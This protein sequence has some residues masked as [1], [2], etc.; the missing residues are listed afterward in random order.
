MGRCGGTASEDPHQ[1]GTSGIRHAEP[2]QSLVPIASPFRSRK[3][4]SNEKQKRPPPGLGRS[5]A[6]GYAPG[7][8]RAAAGGGIRP[9]V[10][11]LRTAE[12][13]E[14]QFDY[15]P[16][17][18]PNKPS[19]QR[20][21]PLGRPPDDSRPP[22]PRDHPLTCRLS[23]TAPRSPLWGT[24]PRFGHPA[25][26]SP[27]RSL[28]PPSGLR[29]IRHPNRF[30]TAPTSYDVAAQVTQAWTPFGGMM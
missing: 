19:Y 11:L 20:E 9:P 26:R 28:Y 1:T 21:L 23:Q 24:P 3:G 12:C 16:K 4:R 10:G 17:E 6:L 27:S 13:L 14:G 25:P 22:V 2:F 8:L 15:T 5:R 30:T 29:S 18:L 7:D